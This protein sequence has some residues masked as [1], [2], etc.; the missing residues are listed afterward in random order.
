MRCWAGSR[1]WLRWKARV[2][3]PRVLTHL[4][5]VLLAHQGLSKTQH[6]VC[7]QGPF[8]VPAKGCGA[9]YSPIQVYSQ[10]RL[11]FDTKPA[12]IIKPKGEDKSRHKTLP[13][14]T[15]F[16]NWKS[17]ALSRVNKTCQRDAATGR[18]NNH[19]KNTNTCFKESRLCALPAPSAYAAAS[20]ESF[21]DTGTRPF[22]RNAG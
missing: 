12:V 13:I 11:F 4:C 15:A 9:P 5:H 18:G 21:E 6:D 8:R 10:E 1:Q 17:A 19:I 7:Y 2:G 22:L 16:L 20:P 14:A 3:C